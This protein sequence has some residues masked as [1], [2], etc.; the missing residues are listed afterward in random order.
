MYCIDE[1]MVNNNRIRIYITTNTFFVYLQLNYTWEWHAVHLSLYQFM[2]YCLSSFLMNLKLFNRCIVCELPVFFA[3][4][5]H[6]RKVLLCN[7][8]N[9]HLLCIIF[10]SSVDESTVEFP[11]LMVIS[12]HFGS[13]SEVRVCF[14]DIGSVSVGNQIYSSIE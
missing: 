5:F 6:I 11:M 14:E 3:C 2:S 13:Y 10:G 9:S 12:T 8:I 1:R 7:V 4:W